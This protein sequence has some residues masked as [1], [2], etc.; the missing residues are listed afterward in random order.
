MAGKPTK[1]NPELQAKIIAR[2]QRGADPDTAA[3]AEGIDRA[4]YY[5]WM[6]QG[7]EDV[8]SGKE[9]PVAAFAMS[10]ARACAERECGLVER[11]LEGDGQG[12]GFGPAKAASEFLRLTQ[13]RYGERVR[14]QVADELEE[15]LSI[16]ERICRPE[17]FARVLEAVAARDRGEEA[18]EPQGEAAVH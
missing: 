17:D 16:V 9:T 7:R 2:V 12:L 10:V 11:W 6:K 15:L 5:R 18:G 13:R 3:Q 1:L 8:D 4:T 14:I